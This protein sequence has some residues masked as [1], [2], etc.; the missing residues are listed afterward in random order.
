MIRFIDILW[1]LSLYDECNT[2][3]ST[4]RA[5]VFNKGSLDR[6]ERLNFNFSRHCFTRSRRLGFTQPC[7]K[8]YLACRV[9]YYPNSTRCLNLSR[10][11][12]LSGNVEL[13]PGMVDQHKSCCIKNLKMVHLNICSLKNRNHYINLKIW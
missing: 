3:H 13:N 9:L 12:L 5:K 10:L 6:I 1:S 4:I 11:V 8:K 7:R 2:H